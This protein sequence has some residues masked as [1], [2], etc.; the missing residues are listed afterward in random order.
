MKTRKMKKKPNL[1]QLQKGIKDFEEKCATRNRDWKKQ[2]Q[3]NANRRPSKRQ[4][5]ELTI[6][7]YTHGRD[8]ALPHLGRG[9]VIDTWDQ[10]DRASKIGNIAGVKFILNAVRKGEV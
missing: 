5:K 7:A 4:I 1:N 6:N 9:K 8:R 3:R 2:L 10:L